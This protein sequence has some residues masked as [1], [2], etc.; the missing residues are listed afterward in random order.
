MFELRI[1]GVVPLL[2]AYLLSACN[3]EAPTITDPGAGNPELGIAEFRVTEA[4]DHFDLKGV[5]AEGHM[6]ASIELRVGYVDLRGER[7]AGVGRELLVTFNGKEVKHQSVGLTPLSLPQL[8]DRD[9]SRFM[10]DPYVAHVLERWGIETVAEVPGLALSPDE[11]AY[12]GDGSCSGFP[13]P[14][15]STPVASCCLQGADAS[16]DL[17]QLVACDSLNPMRISE[18]TC[19]SPGASTACGMAGPGGCAVCWTM[20]HDATV[21]YTTTYQPATGLCDFASCGWAG[22]FCTSSSQCCEGFCDLSGSWGAAN[23]CVQN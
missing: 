19:R 2:G 14:C 17:R 6:K 5:D 1:A 9:L 11:T 10:D 18:R 23:E 3:A 20:T 16:G 8:Q 4:K 12:T 15:M 7:L 21:Q 22:A 13:P